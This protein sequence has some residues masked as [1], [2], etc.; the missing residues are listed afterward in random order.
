ML[1][2]WSRSGK[3][4]LIARLLQHY[5]LHKIDPKNIFIYSPSFKSDK[6]FQSVRNYLWF[7]LQEKFEQHVEDL[8]NMDKIKEIIASQYKALQ[9]NDDVWY[10]K[11]MST[12]K[13]S[14]TSNNKPIFDQNPEPTFL[15]EE[16][17]IKEYLI[18]IDDNL[19]SLK[20]YSSEL[21]LL[22]TKSRHYKIWII[23]T[24][25]VFKRMPSTVRYNSDLCF[26]LYFTINDDTLAE[27]FSKK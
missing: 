8:P 18:I 25:Q 13:F 15:T 12:Q 27:Q 17:P 26:Y 23:W 16:L 2:G 6:S 22:C 21:S 1:I 10:W 9:L 11:Q 24:S 20:S 5:Y 3:G 14:Q 19:E 4:V 7:H